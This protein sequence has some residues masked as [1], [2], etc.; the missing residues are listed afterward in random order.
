MRIEHSLAS[1]VVWNVNWVVFFNRYTHN[2]AGKKS[3]NDLI[4]FKVTNRVE[5]SCQL[6]NFQSHQIFLWTWDRIKVGFYVSFNGF[7]LFWAHFQIS[8]QVID[9]SDGPF[10]HAVSQSNQRI[11][12]PL[13]LYRSICY[14]K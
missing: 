12:F 11:Y 2:S 14:S 13:S 10:F 8:E 6:L 7:P 9:K 1:T 4:W 5:E 3:D